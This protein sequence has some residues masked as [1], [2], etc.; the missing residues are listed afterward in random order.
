LESVGFGW[1]N[2]SPEELYNYTP[3]E[4]DNHLRGFMYLRDLTERSHW[5]RS[6]L[7]TATLLMPH[8]KKGANIRPEKLWPFDWDKKNKNRGMRISDKRLAYLEK[9]RKRG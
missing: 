4:F 7:S 5:E 3:S 2:L 9:K 8:S 6:R 1:L